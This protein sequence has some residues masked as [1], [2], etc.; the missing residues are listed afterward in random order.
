[1]TS[2][3]KTMKRII[4]IIPKSLYMLFFRYN[5]RR[6]NKHNATRAI[7]RFHS[8]NVSVGKKTYGPI[9]I[10]YD[11][12]SG[13]L[14]I[15]NYCSLANSVKFF[16][17]G[18]HNYKKISTF[19]FQTKVYNGIGASHRNESL[20]IIVEDDVWIG[21]DCIVLAGAKIGKGSVIGA[22]SIVT[23]TIPPYSVYVGNK[24]I[25]K[26]FSDDIITVIKTIDFS[27]IKHFAGDHYERYCNEELSTK[28]VEEIRESFE[29]SITIQK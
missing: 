6:S 8:E 25:K 17:G 29:K 24:V 11:S 19:P 22:R 28:N 4:K 23:G 12:G 16:L 14:S 26:R 20:D 2:R 10:L 21:Y 3:N 7:N 18:E 27:K 15:G 1:M 9:E 5:W 13:K